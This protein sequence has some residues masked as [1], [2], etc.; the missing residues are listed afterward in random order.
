MVQLIFVEDLK[1]IQVSFEYNPKLV[2]LVKTIPGRRFNPETKQWSIPSNQA[3]TAIDLFERLGAE[4]D[5]KIYELG[6]EKQVDNTLS[7][8][9]L[10]A[11]IAQ[12]ISLGFPDPIWVVGEILDF[13]KTKNS[14]GHKYFKL[15]EKDPDD[16]NTKA[17][18]SV[19]IWESNFQKI[20]N[21]LKKCPKPFEL[22]NGLEVRFLVSLSFWDKGGSISLSVVDIDP[23]YTVGKLAEN[24]EKIL[25][26]LKKMG[27]LEKNSKLP[28][29]PFANRIGVV[30]S[31]TSAGFK[32]F[33]TE[34]KSS[35]LDFYI[36]AVNANV[37]GKNVT[38]TVLAALAYFEKRVEK[39]DYVIIIRGG[40]ATADLLGFDSMELGVAVANFPIKII[41]GIGHEKDKTILDF[42]TQSEKTP[43][44]VAT[45]LIDALKSDF[46]NMESTF[47]RLVQSAKKDLRLAGEKLLN[48]RS[49]LKSS[50]I[51]LFSRE[52][53]TLTHRV[54][55][56]KSIVKNLLKRENTLLDSIKKLVDSYH[57]KQ[58]L[59]KGYAFITLNSG[60]QLK[61]K[62]TASEIKNDPK[63]EIHFCDGSVNAE[64]ISKEN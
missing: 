16:Q 8:S 22:D 44:K 58:I 24:R 10:N 4:I 37:Q 7:I 42:I 19:T 5:P 32:D 40:G 52:K 60:K 30:A 50:Y 39:F 55:T 6:E 41:C 59:K 18:A 11:K 57:P 25:A 31:L 20:S 23:V 28:A 47:E 56:L 53:A 1:L 38:K 64:I 63:I 3:A 62:P 36:T 34:I 15:I 2:A 35:K 33:I 14:K 26:E 21:K 9:R 13:Q 17:E 45:F 49:T 43:T 48:M 29:I 27:L 46:D 54:E 51:G 12:T 61:S